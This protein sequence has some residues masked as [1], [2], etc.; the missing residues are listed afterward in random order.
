MLLCWYFF[1]KVWCE[2]YLIGMKDGIKS[3]K[4]GLTSFVLLTAL[5][6][7]TPVF[8]KHYLQIF[9][10]FDALIKSGRLQIGKHSAMADSTLH[11]EWF[12]HEI[13]FLKRCQYI[14]MI[15]RINGGMSELSSTHVK[16]GDMDYTRVTNSKGHD[17]SRVSMM[18]SYALKCINISWR[19]VKLWSFVV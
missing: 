8:M 9:P 17:D 5:S 6:Q 4:K 14:S 10:G 7:F 1:G 16:T 15:Y 13:L 19:Q 12:W 11:R 18:I 3:T 2:G